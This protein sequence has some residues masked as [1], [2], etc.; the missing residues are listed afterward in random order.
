MSR[1]NITFNKDNYLY[2]ELAK[3]SKDKTLFEYERS[4]SK[5][6]A[7]QLFLVNREEGYVQDEIVNG[8]RQDLKKFLQE[9]IEDGITFEL[10]KKVAKDGRV[11]VVTILRY[12]LLAFNHDQFHEIAEQAID[13]GHLQ[14]L[15]L[16]YNMFIDNKRLLT[17][18]SSKGE[19]EIVKYIYYRSSCFGTSLIPSL[20]ASIEG[21][22]YS[23]SK[24]LFSS[25]DGWTKEVTSR[26]VNDFYPKSLDMLEKFLE[27]N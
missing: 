17:Y 14:V 15:Q 10:M 16:L 6:I 24:F 26:Y 21:E 19:E 23:I 8:N 4:R 12:G 9:D 22:H 20:L 27:T 7:S 18:A 11:E 5:S 1:I 3:T 25:L 2:L 13:G